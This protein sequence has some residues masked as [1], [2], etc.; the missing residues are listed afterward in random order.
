MTT[1]IRLAD[2][3]HLSVAVRGEGTP[4]LLIRP[5]GGSLV[6][7]GSFAETLASGARVVAFDARGSGCSSA[8]PLATT[9]RSMAADAVAVLDA[10]AIGRAD[11]AR[12]VHRVSVLLL[13]EDLPHERI[14]ALAKSAVVRDVALSRPLFV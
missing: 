5:L 9:T 2:G 8:A 11:V 12:V 3:G 13:A 7:W 14:G 4:L 1:E 10:F 6:C